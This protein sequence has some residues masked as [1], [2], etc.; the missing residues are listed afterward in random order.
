MYT[1]LHYNLITLKK[2]KIYFTDK[3]DNFSVTQDTR[4]EE[5]GIY[6]GFFYFIIGLFISILLLLLFI[7]F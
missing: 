6:G 2:N 3:L 7:L 5:R 1:H 4:E